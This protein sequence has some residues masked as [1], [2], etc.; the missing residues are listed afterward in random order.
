MVPMVDMLLRIGGQAE[1]ECL[2]RYLHDLGMYNS[3]LRFPGEEDFMAQQ[4][5]ILNL[6]LPVVMDINTVTLANLLDSTDHYTDSSLPEGSSQIVEVAWGH[7]F[8]FIVS[9]ACQRRKVDGLVSIPQALFAHR[10]NPNAPWRLTTVWSWFSKRYAG[11]YQ[12]GPLTA[13]MRFRG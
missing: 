5:N 6:V 2:A 9:K 1:D 10:A 13:W 11:L 8:A 12:E 3:P 7:L 4:L